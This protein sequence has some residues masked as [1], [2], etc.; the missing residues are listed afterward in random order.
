MFP[1]ATRRSSLSQLEA[2]FPKPGLSMAEPGRPGL[3]PR[4]IGR[5]TPERHRIRA[6]RSKLSYGRDHR[7]LGWP[8]TPIWSSWPSAWSRAAR[9]CRAVLHLLSLA[10]PRSGRPILPLLLA[11]ARRRTFRIWAL[12]APIECKDLLK[13]RATARATVRTADRAPSFV[14]W[15][16][17]SSSRRS[18]S[19][20]RR[21][22]AA[23]A[24][25]S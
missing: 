15:T 1:R 22:M 8:T 13:E 21:S 16:R 20:P 5:S 3:N 25:T 10:L 23:P 2:I 7:R 14:T 6:R 24:A 4:A 18:C 17:T 12:E 19:W 11:N 9:D